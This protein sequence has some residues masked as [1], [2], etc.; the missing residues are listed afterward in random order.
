VLK[1]SLLSLVATLIVGTASLMVA[2]NQAAASVPVWANDV[3]QDIT[4]GCQIAAEV[5]VNLLGTSSGSVVLGSVAVAS[6]SALSFGV[7][8]ASTAAPVAA[9]GAATATATAA[10]TAGAVVGGGA[11]LASGGVGLIALATFGAVGCSTINTL[12]FLFGES[13]P[14]PPASPSAITGSALQSC[15][16]LGRTDGIQAGDLCVE[17][18]FAAGTPGSFEVRSLWFAPTYGFHLNGAATA[19]K[20]RATDG[21]AVLS[22]PI[23]IGGAETAV[24]AL[25]CNGTTACGFPPFLEW[26][27]SHDSPG[28]GVIPGIAAMAGSNT[29]ASG[30]VDVQRRERGY[31]RRLTGVVE[32]KAPGGSPRTISG[33]SSTWYDGDA[34][35]QRLNADDFVSGLRCDPGEAPIDINIQRQRLNI[36]APQLVPTEEWG[37]NQ[38][39]L[40]STLPPEVANNADSLQCFVVGV[41]NCPIW[42]DTSDPTKS[43]LGGQQGVEFPRSATR[44]GTVVDEMV[45]SAPW[46]TQDPRPATTTTAAPSTTAVTTTVPTTTTTIPRTPGDPQ[47]PPPEGSEGAECLPDGWGWFNPIEWVLKP[48]KCAL[49]WAFWDEDVADELAELGDESGWVDTITGSSV[50]TST[51]SA[52]CIDMDVAEICAQELLEVEAPGWVSAL[53][54]AVVSFFVLFEIVGLFSRITRT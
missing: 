39:V 11:T 24:L 43:R 42:D 51:A 32:C 49:L 26:D 33:V 6:P 23:P 45:E 27:D 40:R 48:V 47:P 18:Q 52:P 20:F 1:K 22:V 38:T 29:Y 53:I 54:A 2:P 19:G 36:S 4:D 46:P 9:G 10:G 35:E 7:A 50:S 30:F 17:V 25:A 28:V 41:T 5:P 12:E 14:T 31:Q 44:V 13:V 8:G 34:I 3:A 37:T 21:E 16:A 15:A